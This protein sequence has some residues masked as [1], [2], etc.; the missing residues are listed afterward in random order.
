MGKKK[1]KKEKVERGLSKA[2]LFGEFASLASSLSPEIYRNPSKRVV[3]PHILRVLSIRYP[4]ARACINYRSSQLTQLDWTIVGPKGKEIPGELIRFFKHPENRYRGLRHFL[5]KLVDDLLTLDNIAIEK[6]FSRNGKLKSLRVGDAATIEVRTDESGG[7]PEPPEPAYRQVIGGRVVAEWTANEFIFECMNPRTYSP[8]GL[9]PL[10]SL[11][12]QASSALKIDKYNLSLFEESNIPAGFIY[13]DDTIKD[14]DQ[15][16]KWQRWFD[17]F[18]SGDLGMLR[19]LRALPKDFR[20]EAAVKP[21]DMEFADFQEW[22]LLATCSVF[23]VPPQAIGYTFQ[24]NRATSEVQYRIGQDRGLIPLAQFFKEILDIIIQEDLGYE[25][26]EWKWTT[27]NT[28]DREAESRIARRMIEI[29]AMDIDE[30]RK[31]DGRE[32]YG[33]NRPFVFT[34]GSVIPLDEA[35]EVIPTISGIDS[36]E[37]ELR[38]RKRKA[39]NDIDRYGEVVRP[40][41]YEVVPSSISLKLEGLLTGVK[42]KQEVNKVFSLIG[43]SIGGAFLKRKVED[44]KEEYISSF[45]NEVYDSFSPPK[46]E[47]IASVKRAAQG[48]LREISRLM[49]GG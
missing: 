17:A 35:L 36:I 34:G 12:V 18:M 26:F 41:N 20:Y 22:L 11:I 25:E 29:G 5:D 33:I 27:L 24:I 48:L 28:R 31:E 37:K 3:S 30:W 38:V 47:N 44:L 45:E 10:E 19:K 46:E 43:E 1:K 13:V 6:V 14:P 23:G 40:F 7:M 49:Q 21:E 42:S 8:Y 32:P 2:D 15:L 9:A 4:I 16:L 39:L